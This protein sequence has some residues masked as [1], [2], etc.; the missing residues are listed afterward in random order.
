MTVG[1]ERCKSGKIIIRIL[2]I[3]SSKKF[4]VSAIHPSVAMMFNQILVAVKFSPASLFALEKGIQLAKSHDATLYLFHALDYRLQDLSDTDPRIIAALKEVEKQFE[5]EVIPRL[6]GLLDVKYE[7][8]PADPALEV[9][10]IA[11]AIDADLIV[12]GCHEIRAKM[13]LG[14]V[15]YVGMTILEKAHCPIILVPY[16]Q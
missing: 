6:A 15:D 10:K 4:A 8:R 14:R 2:K 11:R 7:F 1:R 3:E 9:C 12:L 5:S 16:N 13:C